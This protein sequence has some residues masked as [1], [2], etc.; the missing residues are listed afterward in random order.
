MVLLGLRTSLKEDIDTSAAELVY[1]TTLRLPGEYFS[2]EDPIGCPQMFRE[3]LRERIRA[4]RP[5]STSHHIKKKTFIYK[6]LEE[7]THVFVR[8]DKPR[9]LLERPYEGPFIILERLSQYLFSRLIL[10]EYQR[11]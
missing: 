7:C 9:R 4:I 8:V 10:K 11:K 2:A 1:G 5:R 3:N 6:E